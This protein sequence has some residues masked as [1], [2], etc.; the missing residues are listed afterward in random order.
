MKKVILMRCGELMLKGLNRPY[1]EKMLVNSIKKA[2]GN[3]GE[4]K[5]IKTQ[6][7]IF[8]EPE[9]DDYDI[10]K[11]IRAVSKVFGIVSSS[12]A[13][14]IP[15]EINEVIRTTILITEELL[16]QN[17]FSSFK[18]IAKRADKS[19][20]LNSPEI[21]ALAGGK[22]LEKFPRLRVDVQK[23]DFT[24][25]IEIRESA[26]LYTEIIPGMGGLPAG[27]NGRGMLLLS[28]GIDSPVAGWMMA[29]R[30]LGLNAVHFQSPPFTSERSLEK[31]KELAG[32]L[33]IYCG[34]IKLHI[35]P[36]TKIQLA[37]NE[38]CP[39]DEGTVITR[40]FMMRIAEALA[41]KSGCQALITG[42]S[43][44][45][46]ASQTIQSINAINEVVK[47]PVFR[48]LIGIDKNET[49][50]IARKID[51]YDT[52]IL[53]FEDCCTVFVAKHPN[54]RP[55]TKEIIK[56]EKSL[57]IDELTADAIDSI[58]IIDIE[59]AYIR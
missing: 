46:V 11:G 38:K 22:V 16:K 21:C 4:S 48:P 57:N 36:F 41:A 17:N 13:V 29:R 23:P 31:V 37:I 51:T 56:S 53:P 54:I 19:F 30:G 33:S 25:Y 45:Q 32:I 5:I 40:R 50:D 8:L 49:V 44:G 15:C 18:I 26:Y 20:E 47:M 24:I 34:A 59:P 35:V 9:F 28:G 58:E 10:K 7:R 12:D 42:E 39:L 2:V 43:V 6:G 1:F 52:S 14:K 55:L 27:T 3:L